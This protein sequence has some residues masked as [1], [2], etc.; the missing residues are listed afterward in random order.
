MAGWLCSA[1]Y[2]CIEASLAL[3]QGA[4]LT[5]HDQGMFGALGDSAP[6]SGAEG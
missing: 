5:P 3:G 1:D 6:I 4:F 2:F